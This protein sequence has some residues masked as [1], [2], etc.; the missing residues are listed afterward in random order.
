[1]ISGGQGRR[2]DTWGLAC[3]RERM[4]EFGLGFGFCEHAEARMS[5]SLYLEFA[6]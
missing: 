4:R 5:R 1:M 2:S 6:V 3:V